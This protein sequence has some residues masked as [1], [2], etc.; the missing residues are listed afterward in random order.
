MLREAAKKVFFNGPATKALPPL[1]SLVATIFFG[2]YLGLKK[3]YF[4]LVSK[5]LPS[6]PHLVAGQLEKTFFAASLTL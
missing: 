6:P 2:I 1:S 5:P 3:R 4:F